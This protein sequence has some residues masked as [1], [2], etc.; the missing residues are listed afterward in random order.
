MP[1]RSPATIAKV[2]KTVTDALYLGAVIGVGQMPWF[3]RVDPPGW[4]QADRFT[5]IAAASIHEPLPLLAQLLPGAPVAP[6][7]GGSVCHVFRLT[8]VPRRRP[9]SN[10]GTTA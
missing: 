3:T 1:P 7:G 10:H 9:D 4:F 6:F 8:R 5:A 2:A